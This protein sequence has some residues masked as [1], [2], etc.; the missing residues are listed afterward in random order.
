E[1]TA[2]VRQL[3]GTSKLDYGVVL[4][5]YRYLQKD[6]LCETRGTA[7]D[8][9]EFGLTTKGLRRAEEAYRK[10]PYAGAAPVP[11]AS[12]SQSSRDQAFRPQITTESLRQCLLDL[13]VPDSTI[14]DLGAAL[15]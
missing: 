11:L 12:Y 9:I 14:R 7:G 1:G 10:N 4:S 15:M 3:M 8:D 5:A 2:S 6:Q 13:V